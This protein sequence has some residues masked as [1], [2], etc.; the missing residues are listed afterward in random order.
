MKNT[1][2][3]PFWKKLRKL[4]I[5]PSAVEW[6]QTSATVVVAVG[7]KYLA[8]PVELLSLVQHWKETNWS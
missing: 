3:P 5:R 1:F 7:L 2:Q 6:P 4:P 8:R